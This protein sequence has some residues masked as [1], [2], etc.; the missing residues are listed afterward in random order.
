M[1]GDSF[2]SSDSLTFLIAYQGSLSN[3][4]LHAHYNEPP[5]PRRQHL[6]RMRFELSRWR[7]HYA[8]DGFI[9]TQYSCDGYYV[10]FIS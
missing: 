7:V 1:V 10:L 9:A 5:D 8:Y 6:V 2:V 3:I 4:D